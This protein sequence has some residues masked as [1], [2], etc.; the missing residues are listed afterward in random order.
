MKRVLC[1]WLPTF[2]TDLV[3]RRLSRSGA[4]AS[5]GHQRGAAIVLTRPVASR[6]L[7]IRRCMIARAAGIIEGMDLAHARSLLPAGTALHTEAHRPDRDQAALHALACWALRFSPAVAPDPPDGLMIDITGTQRL[8]RNESK[9]IRAVASGIL[10]LGFAARVATA[11]TFGCAWAVSRFGKHPLSRV[12][13]GC[14]REAIESLPVAALRIDE[15]TQ[16]GLSEVGMIQVSNLL[17][18]PRSSLASRFDPILLRRLLQ[19]LGE[20]GEHI[21]PVRPMPPA[22][23]ELLFDGPTDHWESVEAAARQVLEQLVMELAR[24]ERG[25][26][27]LDLRLLRPRAAPTS[28]QITLSRPSRALKHLWSLLRSRLERTDLGEGVEGVE[29]IASR[30]ARLRH[31][32]R[33]SPALGGDDEHVAAGA[34]G[35]LTDTLVSRLGADNIVHLDPVE[36][37]IPERAFRERSVME[38]AAPTPQPAVTRADR[39]PILFPRPEP[40]DTMALTPDGPILSLGWRGRRW[41]VLSCSAPERI[42]QEWWRWEPPSTS[43]RRY[44]PVTAP[45][46]RDYFAVQTEEGRWLWMCRH[47][48]TSTWFVHG[49]WS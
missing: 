43:Q 44:R 7:V 27:R 16:Q 3:K 30:T 34:W 18:L 21:E 35:E 11:P 41:N 37:H 10:R 25:V 5:T 19:A 4:S 42:G 15:A 49:E 2:S 36:T 45:P 38:P 23:C 40:A 14:E 39:P 48:G 28:I 26:R 31:E 1:V 46:D 29:L 12:P 13:N 20:A 32:Q 17:A 24:R 6:E 8:H 22:Q 9:L 47:A 33:V